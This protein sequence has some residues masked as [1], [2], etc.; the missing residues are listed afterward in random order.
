MSIT[1]HEY[2]VQ[3]DKIMRELLR[4]RH[5]AG[6]NAND[7]LEPLIVALAHTIATV[8]QLPAALAAGQTAAEQKAVENLSAVLQGKLAQL[9]DQAGAQMA[10]AAKWR[11]FAIASV[12]FL[13]ICG[14]SY[15]CASYM[16]DIW[17]N[18]KISK[19]EDGYS[20]SLADKVKSWSQATE[21]VTSII[22]GKADDGAPWPCVGWGTQGYGLTDL[23]FRKG[24]YQV[25]TCSI[26]LRWKD[27]PGHK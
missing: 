9:I 19:L 7:P 27:P 17:A 26:A 8:G 11:A 3:C 13:V 20:K 16:T 25:V 10:A 4:V 21:W 24:N 15:Y 22:T 12:V 5:D 1:P 2:W 6:I 23:N 14:T 18:E